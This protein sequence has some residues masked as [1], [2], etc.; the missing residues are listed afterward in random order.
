[1]KLTSI[2]LILALCS[3]CGAVAVEPNARTV[4]LG[5]VEDVFE[6]QGDMIEL[7]GGLPATYLLGSALEAD[8]FF[9]S[10]ARIIEQYGELSIISV[11]DV[12]ALDELQR[13]ELQDAALEAALDVDGVL[14]LD[15]EGTSSRSLGDQRPGLHLVHVDSN[16]L[17]VE[18]L[19]LLT[20]TPEELE[21]FLSERL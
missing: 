12:S 13:S 6:G 20:A 19:D 11:L 8:D 16:L 15:I 5:S 7:S 14:L 10:R 4:T 18:D 9:A 1:M 3:A 17:V 2:L 21:S